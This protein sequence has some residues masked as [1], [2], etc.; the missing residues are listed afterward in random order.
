MRVFDSETAD[1]LTRFSDV[2][3]T[4]AYSNVRVSDATKDEKAPPEGCAIVTVSSHCT[5]HLLLKGLIKSL[6][7]AAALYLSW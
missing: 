1:L 6:S 3:G 2:I 5:A 4:L 7:L